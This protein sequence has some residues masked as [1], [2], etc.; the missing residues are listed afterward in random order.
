[1]KKINLIFKELFYA[2]TGALV[3][4][5]VLELA[6]PNI[7]LAYLNL[8]WVLLSWLFA[9]IIVLVTGKEEIKK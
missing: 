1:M 6:W 8:N 5:V 9:G 2:L 3:I 7:V 4:F